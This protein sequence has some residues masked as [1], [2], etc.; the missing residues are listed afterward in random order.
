M[1]LPSPPGQRRAQHVPGHALV[2]PG[3]G[4][5]HGDQ[6]RHGLPV[7]GSRQEGASASIRRTRT[8][9]AADGT[10]KMA[11]LYSHNK[12]MKNVQFSDSHGHRWHFVRVYK[13]DRYGRMLTRER[14]EVVADNDPGQ[15][16]EV[17]APQGH[18]PREGH[19]VRRLPRRPGRARRRRRRSST[20]RCATSSPSAAGTVTARRPRARPL[21]TSGAHRDRRPHQ[22]ATPFGK[23]W[24]ERQG[25][26]GHPALQDEGRP[27]L[28]GQAGHRL[29]RS[30]PS[31]LQRQG[32]EG[33][34]PAQGRLASVPWP[35]RTTSRTRPNVMECSSCHASWNSGCYGCHLSVR[36]NTKTPEI[37]VANDP[38]RV[39]TDYFPQLLKAENNMMGISGSRGRATRSRP[40][41]PRTRC[42]SRSPSATATPPCTSSPRSPRRA[43]RASRTR[44]TR[45]TRSATRSR[46]TARTATSRRADD[47]N[48][49]LAGV[50][51]MGA[52][53]ANMMGDFVYVAERRRRRAG[54]A[55][56]RGLRA[57]AG[58][59]QLAAPA[60]VSE[61]L[62]RSSSA[63][64]RKLDEVALARAAT[65]C[66]RSCAAASSSTSR[67]VRA[68]S[69]CTTSS[70]SRNKAV[71]QKIIPAA[72]SPLGQSVQVKTTDATVGGAGGEQPDGSQPEV[73]AGEPGAADLADLPVRVHDGQRGR[74]D[75]R[76]HQHVQRRRSDEQLHQ[77]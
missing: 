59:R 25:R 38:T 26:Q 12:D 40:S 46:V 60:V 13:R 11:E 48:A 37:H 56:G 17:A 27:L 64:G 45:R 47:N 53:G 7:V 61:R 23:P 58:H 54:H 72:I 9:L 49:W 29:H 36:V 43:S 52:N 57:A 39:Y 22:G 71:A 73:A 8:S 18:P 4:L 14:H 77:A 32:G 6:A 19:A 74:P 68:G 41:G 76:R 35:A 2:G 3:V 1:T 31:R 30:R 66:A 67:T 20:R 65:T 55:R 70:R 5:R 33:D 28:G 16:Q 62:S 24:M 50:L 42:S 10:P 51:G 75:R 21:K 44:R 15:V 34:G 69:A 63:G